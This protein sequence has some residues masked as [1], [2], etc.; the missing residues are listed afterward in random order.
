MIQR[1]FKR[2]TAFCILFYA[3]DVSC[4]VK[5]KLPKATVT[6]WVHGTHPVKR[7][8]ESKYSPMRSQV[9]APM[10]LSLAKDLPKN[11]NFYNIAV[12]S[13][14]LSPEKYPLDHFYLFGWNSAKITSKQRKKAGRQLFEELDTLLSEYKKRYKVVELRLIGFSHGGNVILNCISNLP[15]SCKDIAIEVALVATPIQEATRWYAN[16]PYVNKVYS[17]YSD[18]D[19]IQRIDMQKFH[20]DAPKQT[21]FLSSRIFEDFDRVIQVNFKFNGKS[22]GHIGYRPVM[23]YIA[24]ILQQIDSQADAT[25]KHQ[26]IG[27]NFTTK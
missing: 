6:V 14:R 11:Y 19:W 27:L 2:V 21:P 7:L 15:F 16:S 25:K 22:I 24:D 12:E 9:Y 13:S 17:L 10:G 3:F 5:T 26:H 8:L 18:A 20:K 23:K 1:C 4:K